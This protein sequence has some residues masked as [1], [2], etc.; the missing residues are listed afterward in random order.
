M[1]L[2]I[3]D[4]LHSVLDYT[5]NILF[6][7]VMVF[8]LQMQ[9]LKNIIKTVLDLKF[10]VLPYDLEHVSQLHSDIKETTLHLVTD[11]NTDYLFFYK[12]RKR[13]AH[14]L[15]RHYLLYVWEAGW[16]TFQVSHSPGWQIGTDCQL[17]DEPG[18]W[19]KKLSSSHGALVI[20]SSS[21][22]CVYFLK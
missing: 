5:V 18:L 21:S 19:A 6:W 9:L 4:S 10:A 7:T 16:F 8:Q 22:Y 20:F 3:Y 15:P 17:E 13:T 11:N 2:K 14:F 1:S 12:L